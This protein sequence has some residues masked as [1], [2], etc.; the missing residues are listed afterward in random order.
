[1]KHTENIKVVTNNKKAYHEYFVKDTLEC[2]ISLKGSEIKSIRDG[3]VSIKESWCNIV[4]GELFV[5]GM[6]I[7]KF[8]N[9]SDYFN[10][11]ELR[12][13]KLLAHKSE[14]E[15]LTKELTLKGMTLVPLKVYLNNRGKVKV[16]IG[17]CK[18]KHNYDKR[19]VN[20]QRD[21]KRDIERVLK[22][23]G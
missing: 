18:G 4:N 3:K 23:R 10:H 22:N 14:I 19:E 1:M 16:E 17:L 12:V 20:K 2:G 9:C 15:K 21:A 11:E 7:S 5:N 6:N 8:S 13:R